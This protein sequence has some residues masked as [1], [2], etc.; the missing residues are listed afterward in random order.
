MAHGDKK[1]IID[2]SGKLKKSNDRT[3]KDYY[4]GV[5][6]WEPMYE[7]TYWRAPA[8]E[9]DMFCPQ[10]KHFGQP[11]MEEQTRISDINYSIHE[12]FKKQYPKY[13]DYIEELRFSDYS[14]WDDYFVE[15]KKRS[16]AKTRDF[17]KFQRD[18]P[19]KMEETWCYHARSYLCDKHRNYYEAKRQMNREMYPYW[20]KR[21][22]EPRR[23]DYRDYKN[24]V[25]WA[26]QKAKN[27]DM[28]DY[29]NIP[30]YKRGWLD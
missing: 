11:I 18:Y 26:M 20:V 16:A 25:K 28:D 5:R 3:K 12:A 13:V 14:T 15:H 19:I 24:S 6:V 23:Q 17:D 30:K 7:R 9:N 1:W 29:E 21:L 10:C 2:F 22:A 4:A 27:G 8:K